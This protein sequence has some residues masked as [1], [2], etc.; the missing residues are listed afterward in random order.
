MGALLRAFWWSIGMKMRI[1]I[2]ILALVACCLADDDMPPPF[3]REL[4]VTSPPMEGND[5]VILQELVSRSPYVSP[6]D[7]TGEYD[8]QTGS[9]VQKFQEGNN[10]SPAKGVFDATTANALLALQSCDNYTD[11]GTPASQLGNYKYKIYV[12]V[13]NNRSWE[14]TAFLYDANN[15]MLHQFRV[16]THGQDSTAASPWPSYSNTVGLN[17]F[18]SN[19][20]TPTG[21]AECDLNS[22][23]PNATL[24]GPFPVNRVINGIDGN[25]AFILD[26]TQPI[27]SGILLHTG[28]WPAPWTPYMDMPNSDGC[29]HAHPKD[30]ETIWQ[31]LVSIGVEVRDNPFGEIPYP[32]TPQGVIAIEQV[33]CQ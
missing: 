6:V 26:K 22:P 31:K 25:A 28:L 9:A 4:Y 16:R 29:L 17:M 11:P 14:H 19:G 18:T 24:Y 32:F 2:L 30:I 21:L 23:E 12:P 8:A 10:I 1:A 27:R 20:N 7:M 5:V 13:F 15:V 3:T 33:G